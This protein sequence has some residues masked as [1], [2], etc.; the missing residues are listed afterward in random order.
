MAYKKKEYYFIDKD[1]NKE[2]LG[3]KDYLELNRLNI[4]ELKLP[5]YVY[6]LACVNNQLTSLDIPENA[7]SVYCYGNKIKSLRVPP[8]VR[9]LTIDK[10]VRIINK[11]ELNPDINI[12]RIANDDD[13]WNCPIFWDTNNHFWR[14]EKDIKELE[15]LGLNIRSYIPLNN[16]VEA[17]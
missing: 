4:T 1:G 9:E 5:S 17:L 3:R 15:R 6:F 12:T 14:P 8:S 10:G 11:K 2:R 16:A 7:H 13:C